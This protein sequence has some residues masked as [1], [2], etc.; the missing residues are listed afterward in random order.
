MA[1][2]EKGQAYSFQRKSEIC[3]PRFTILLTQRAEFFQRTTSFFDPN[4]LT[5]ATAPRRAPQ[6][7][8]SDFNRSERAGSKKKKNKTSQV[9]ARVSGGVSKLFVFR[10]RAN[11][12]NTVP[13]RCT[14][15]FL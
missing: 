6:F 12:S 10:L 9:R 2:D 1:F 3:A 15:A 13:K 7:A 5:V 8:R 4:I 14:P 11:N